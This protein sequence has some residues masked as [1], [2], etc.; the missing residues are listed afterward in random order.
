MQKYKT[1]SVSDNKEFLLKEVPMNHS[2]F[3]QK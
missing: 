1:E 2:T 3:N